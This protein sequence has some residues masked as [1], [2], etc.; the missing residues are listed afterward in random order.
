MDSEILGPVFRRYYE[1]IQGATAKFPESD[2]CEK[3]HLIHLCNMAMAG[4]AMKDL[5]Y[6]KLCRWLGFIQ[7]VLCCMGVT[8]V[9]AERDFTRPIFGGES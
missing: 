8:T 4:I 2:Q 3:A 7:G 6:G 5:P 1:M 9:Q